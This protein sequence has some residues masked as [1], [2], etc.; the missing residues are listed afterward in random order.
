MSKS[1]K[2]KRKKTVARSAAK[3]PTEK[4]SRFT[5]EFFQKKVPYFF[6]ALFV[7]LFVFFIVR[8]GGNPDFEISLL[9]AV[10]W[11]KP[12]QYVL[13]TLLTVGFG[14][15][16]WR[17]LSNAQVMNPT[18]RIVFI[19][20]SAL[21]LIMYITSFSKEISLNG[22]NGEYLII[23]K[24][25]VERGKI[26]RLEVPSETPNSLASLGLPMILAPIYKIWGLDIVKMKILITAMGFSIF[27]LL[28]QLF[29]K[30]GFALATLLAIA[31]ITAP[32]V[33]VNARDIMTE[34]PFLFWSVVA[35]LLIIKY[36]E[37]SR[38]NWK[39]YFLAFGAVIMTYLTRAVG[40]SMVLA[41]IV[42]LFSHVPWSMI[43]TSAGRKKLFSTVEFKKFIYI[44]LPLLIG[45][46]LW[47]IWQY[48]Q[49]I[50]QAGLLMNANLPRQV[51][52]NSQS[53][54]GMIPQMLFRNETFRFQNFYSSAK[55]LPL[56]ALYVLILIII[57]VGLINGF[58]QRNVIAFFV[59]FTGMVIVFASATPQQMVIIRYF[60]V[61]LPFI[62]YFLFTGLVQSLR[63]LF[64]KL[65]LVEK[66]PW[67]VR[68]V[69]VLILAQ[70]FFVNLEGHSVNMTLSR[71]GNGPGY[72]DFVDVARWAKNNLP[73]DAYVVSVKP[74]LFYI[75]SNKRGTR[76]STL[77]EEYSKDYEDEKLALFKRLGIT[78]VVLD[79]ISGATRE[80][81][82]PIVQNHPEMFQ[83]LY[84]GQ[85]SGTSSISKII[86]EN[87]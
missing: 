55:I 64:R 74:R 32:Y 51:E 49:G 67:L 13:F 50:S 77:Q 59:F 58:R 43:Y 5:T 18:D 78:H 81:I 45:G 69:S 85:T 63:Y 39:Y 15:F 70:L 44:M 27:F 21:V 17:Y 14:Y 16:G 37:S 75:L 24:S 11:F 23:T 42:F 22:D 19:A 38:M 36:H 31:G 82:F 53:A 76:L 79:G 8:L 9:K 56:N 66:T 40:I 30:Q 46:V 6:V 25:L 7:G 84:V 68:L 54:F 41:M 73:D 34:T 48:S 57:L 62:I 26:L 60:S 33:V 72:L 61:L 35:L 12:L 52:D 47:Q 86:Y 1:V 28:Y 83:T 87:Q 10:K 65:K 4:T 3:P 80:N 2:G 29:K 71:V 20:V